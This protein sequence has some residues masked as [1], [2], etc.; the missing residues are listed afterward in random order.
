MGFTVEQE[1]PQCGAPIDLD[2][3]D[4]LI[5]CPYCHVK[6]YLFTQD[7][8]RFVLPHKA[9]NQDII[10]APYMRFKGEVYLCEGATIGH[11]IVDITYQGTIFKQ[12]PISLGLRPQAMKMKFVTPDVHGSFLKCSLRPLDVLAN[13]GKRTSFFSPGRIFHRA[14][15]GEAFSLIFLPLFVQGGR[16]FDAVINKPITALPNGE[17]I[18]PLASEEDSSWRITFMATICPQ[19]GWDLDGE[20]DSVVL[21]CGNCDTAW[22]ASEGRLVQVDFSVVPGKGNNVKYLPFWKIAVRDEGLGINTYA[23]FIRITQLPTLMQRDWDNKE[24]SFWI[25][26]FK[27][28]PKVFLRLAREITI[29]QQDFAMGE[30]IPKKTFYPVTLPK[31]EAAQSLK[32]T[33]ASSVMAKKEFFP[34]LPQVNF[35][36]MKFNLIHLP[37]RSMGLDMIQEDMG[38]SI[39]KNALKYGRYL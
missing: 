28:R 30:P 18:F 34:L 16:V 33:L 15:I 13:V 37:F 19:C 6:N 39:N 29:L 38:I 24:L 32:V 8:F 20:S 26:A 35:T 3:T 10:Y 17:D 1:C 7:Y 12:L 21:N 22:E 2:E 23:D 5:L 9:P 36:I 31:G 4:R 27:I 14:Y 25:P 11:S